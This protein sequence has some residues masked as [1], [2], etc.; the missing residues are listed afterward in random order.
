MVQLLLHTSIQRIDIRE[1]FKTLKSLIFWPTFFGEFKLLQ[2]FHF[3]V[4][5]LENSLDL[6]KIAEHTKVE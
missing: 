2:M 1:I 5:S 4:I 6:Q 3:N